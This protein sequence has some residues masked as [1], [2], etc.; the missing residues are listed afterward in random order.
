MRIL[1][2][3][4]ALALACVSGTL[5]SYA[6]PSGGY[7]VH[8]L[9][10]SPGDA[11][12]IELANGSNVLVN[13]GPESFGPR[14]VLLLH[15]ANVTTIDALVTTDTRSDHVGGCAAVLGSM[16]VNGL[17]APGFADNSPTWLAFLKALDAAGTPGYAWTYGIPIAWSTTVTATVLN[18]FSPTAEP[19]GPGDTLALAIDYFDPVTQSVTRTLFA[20][21]DGRV[22]ASLNGPVTILKESSHVS[23]ATLETSLLSVG[24]PWAIVVSYSRSLDATP[25]DADLLLALKSWLGDDTRFRT[26][27]DNGSITILVGSQGCRLIS[28][29]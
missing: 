8:V 20:D 5:A 13:C 7:T 16:R 6:Q 23:K 11:T 3:L 24:N 10:V 25:P 1:I 4:V 14:L 28:D 26:T 18:P 2:W 12:W 15:S 22:A 19:S 17:I 21:D 27:A 9:D 29:R